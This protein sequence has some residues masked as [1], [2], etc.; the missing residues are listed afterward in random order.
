MYYASVFFH[1]VSCIVVALFVIPL[2]VKEARVKNG[3]ALLRKQLLAFGFLVATLAI[4]GAT[5][6]TL[7]YF[8]PDQETR[9]TITV[10][11]VLAHSLGFLGM[12]VIGYKMYH[13]QYTDESKLLHAKLDK[14][15]KR[16]KAMQ[17]SR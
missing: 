4:V 13:Q 10:M 15:E 2:Q 6:L 16:R 8:V 1:I 12:A 9:M 5:V 17:E 3:L 11:L 14:L 7:R